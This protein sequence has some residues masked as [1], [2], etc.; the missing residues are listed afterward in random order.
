MIE[1]GLSDCIP[2]AVWKIGWN[3]NIQAVGTAEQTIKYLAPYV[4]RVAISDTGTG[5]SPEVQQHLFDPAFST[6]GTR[7]KAGM[8]LMV[9]L[10]IV[11]K[12]GGRIEVE[13]EPGKGSTFTLVGPCPAMD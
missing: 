6:K 10:N 12:H 7:I 9:S 3:V 11:Q 13:S 2:P 5:M 8:G 4:F 1:A